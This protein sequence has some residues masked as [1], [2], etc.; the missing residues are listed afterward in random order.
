MEGFPVSVG[1]LV[2]FVC[3]FV[4]RTR[5][6]YSYKI[7]E[8]IRLVCAPHLQTAHFG[9]DPDNFTYPR[10][11]IDF[12]FCRAYEDGAP[13]NTAKHYFKWSKTG[14]TKGEL[15]FVTGNPGSTDRL[16]VA[17]LDGE[18]RFVLVNAIQ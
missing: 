12:S 15:V 16:R 2:V 9:G 8:D 11:S 4:C 1:F 7:F 13:A 17:N 3:S 14:P 10:Y 5:S 6:R 18:R